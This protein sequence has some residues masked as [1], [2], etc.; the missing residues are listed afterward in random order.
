MDKAHFNFYGDSDYFLV[1]DCRADGPGKFGFSSTAAA[2]VRYPDNGIFRRCEAY[3][4]EDSTLH[5]EAGDGFAFNGITILEDCIAGNN[6]DTG[7]DLYN[8][9][10]SSTLIRCIA[11][12]TGKSHYDDPEFDGDGHGFNLR[13]V[14]AP[15][16]L[17]N[18]IAY[19]NQQEGLISGQET[20]TI[21]IYGFTAYNNDIADGN[22]R[23]FYLMSGQPHV[24]RNSIS[25]NPSSSDDMHANV[26]DQFNSWNLGINLDDC[27]LSLEPTNEN[28]LHLDPDGP[29][30]DVG[31]DVGLPYNGTTPDLGAYE[32]A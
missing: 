7:F 14:T 24:I 5:G 9:D 27:F 18:C 22:Q 15:Q 13:L 29:C 10:K 21:T 32:T 12:G 28:F 6:A 20:T 17:K 2:G 31:V 26:D 8:N 30:V 16:I 3:D 25:H 11:Y 4:M 23:N 19:N 1:E